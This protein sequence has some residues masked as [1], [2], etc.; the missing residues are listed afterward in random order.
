MGSCKEKT[1]NLNWTRTK[2]IHDRYSS[3]I[4]RQI[5]LLVYNCQLLLKIKVQYAKTPKGASQGTFFSNEHG[6]YVIEASSS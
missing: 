6:L 5:R 1:L 4:I 3:Y 2:Y